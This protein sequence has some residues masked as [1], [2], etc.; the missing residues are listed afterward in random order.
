MDSSLPG[1]TK[2][3]QEKEGIEEPSQ[4]T[5]V[6]VETDPVGCRSFG[7]YNTCG[8]TERECY[9]PREGGREDSSALV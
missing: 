7:H 1:K 5:S 8:A 3:A 4:K 9:R 2:E 6:K